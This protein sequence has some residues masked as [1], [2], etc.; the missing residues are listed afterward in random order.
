MEDSDSFF[1]FAGPSAVGS[2]P[3]LVASRQSVSTGWVGVSRI[4]SP[5]PALEPHPDRHPRSEAWVSAGR[6]GAAL[7]QGW[8]GGLRADVS[9]LL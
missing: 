9:L 1:R 8:G 7:M 6:G 5:P 2:R 4:D 3:L